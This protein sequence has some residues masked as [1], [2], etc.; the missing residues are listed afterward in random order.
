MKAPVWHLLSRMSVV[1]G[2]T[3]WFR[4]NIIDQAIKHFDEWAFLG[5]R[6]TAHW[7][8]L[9]WDVVNGYVGI[10]VQ[11]GLITLVVFLVL[12]YT[13]LK[14]LLRM[15]LKYPE[16]KQQFLVW[17]LFTIM[18]GHCVALFGVPY[19]GQMRMWWLMT[20]VMVSFLSESKV[21]SKILCCCPT[22]ISTC[23][24]DIILGAKSSDDS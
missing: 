3:G 24:D 22:T 18:S 11:G 13:A 5:C 17:C 8:W 2:S 10:A 19:F 16:R 20:L 7:G 15:S 23:E 12:L 1:P 6:S 21:S 4:Y 14:I 9:M